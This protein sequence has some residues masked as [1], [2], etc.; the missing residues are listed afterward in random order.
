MFR[1]QM[2]RLSAHPLAF[3]N[4]SKKNLRQPLILFF[5]KLRRSHLTLITEF[6]R[7]FALTDCDR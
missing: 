5:P 3:I 6:Q 2:N 4:F 7:K 1:A